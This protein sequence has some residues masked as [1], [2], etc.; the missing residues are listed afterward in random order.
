M[1]QITKD[2]EEIVSDPSIPW[3]K[4][5][6]GI[7]VV[8]GAS[9]LLGSLLLKTLVAIKRKW[10]LNLTIVGISR[11]PKKAESKLRDL[12]GYV[13]FVTL[14]D[15]LEN[16]RADYIIHTGSPTSSA[17]FVS[18][19]VEVINAIYEDL[20]S[21]L[22]FCRKKRVKAFVQLS[23]MEIY[24]DT[25]EGPVN[26]SGQ[27]K[28]DPFS[29]R[30]SYSE[31]KRVAETLCKA[32]AE[33][34]QIPCQVIRLTQ[35]FGAGV[36]IEKDQRVFAD[37]LHKALQRKPIV[38]YTKGETCRSYIYTADAIRAIFVIML[39]GKHSE[40]YNVANPASYCS[41]AEMAGLVAN[42]FGTTVEIRLDSELSRKFNP[43]QK[44]NLDISKLEKL[45]WAPQISLRE[46]FSRMARNV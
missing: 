36:D 33:E 8:T 26:E 12:F 15:F 19:P 16:G 17:F 41:I 40:A 37:F 7:V 5:T 14:P 46:S 24:G 3:E 18:N 22:S 44:I 39:K 31:A 10:N 42:L 2:I 35:C 11:D 9:G 6:D 30:S 28:L 23:T 32:Y 43:T 29:V 25:A 20:N 38:L 45:G 34:Y 4:L 27:G 21:L 13:Q 1:N